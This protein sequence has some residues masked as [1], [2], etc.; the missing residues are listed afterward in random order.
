[1]GKLLDGLI[2]ATPFVIAAYLVI[3]HFLKKNYEKILNESAKKAAPVYAILDMLESAQQASIKP[4]KF[5]L[6][7]DSISSVGNEVI[8]VKIIYNDHELATFYQN[9][10]ETCAQLSRGKI[11]AAVSGNVSSVRDFDE[12]INHLQSNVKQKFFSLFPNT[13]NRLLSNAFVDITNRN[14]IAVS[15]DSIFASVYCHVDDL[16]IGPD[17]NNTPRSPLVL[18]TALSHVRKKF[19]NLDIMIDKRLPTK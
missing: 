13:P 12:R 5:R 7:I 14:S 15:G 16:G 11:Q 6:K 8:E 17:K 19:P 9:A 18:D 10:K 1:M 3:Q 4:V 2:Y